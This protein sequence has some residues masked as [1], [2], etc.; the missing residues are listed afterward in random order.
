MSTATRPLSEVSRLCLG[1]NVFG[2]TM[3]EQESF[4]VLDAFVEGGG[5]FVDTADSYSL[6]VEGHSG[7]ESEAIIGNWLTSRRNR[8]RIVL[9]TKFGQVHGVRADAVHRAVD[10]SLRRLQT[11]R[12]DLLYAHIDDES[13]PLEETLGAMNELVKAGKALT[14]AASGYSAARLAE[15]LAMSDRE[16]WARYEAL[17][18]HYNLVERDAYEG[19]LE[20]LCR[21][22]GLACIPFFSLARGFLTGKY[23]P[24]LQAETKR[25]GFAWTEE[26]DDRTRAV[27]ATLDEVAAAHGTTV[28]A[29]A[30]AW[31]AA[32]PTVLSPIASART[33]E[34]LR[35][36][37][38]MAGL[39]LTDEE[40]ARLAEVGGT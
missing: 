28:A 37:L 4:A 31:L 8:D 27:I 6:W 14:I 35:E 2:W 18:P 10:D 7:G 15:A 25:G 13:V 23:R 24:G 33:P 29:V 19:E 21:R 3:S 32:Q 30:L 17:Q 11:D 26:W 5:N 12:I 9:A 22:E 40:L 39:E 38:P 20:E 34:Q 1:G 36:L 16:G